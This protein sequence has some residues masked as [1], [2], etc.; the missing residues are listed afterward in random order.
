[1]R[2]TMLVVVALLAACGEVAEPREAL[3]YEHAGAM[4]WWTGRDTHRDTYCGDVGGEVECVTAE[5]ELVGGCNARVTDCAP[6]HRDNAS[7]CDTGPVYVL[8]LDE[9]QDAWDGQY[10]ADCL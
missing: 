10:A 2:W 1:M 9:E 3:V 5:G 8:P 6:K 7:C 4:C